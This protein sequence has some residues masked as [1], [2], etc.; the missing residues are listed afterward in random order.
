MIVGAID[1]G[2]N[3]VRIK[4][5][6]VRPD[7][8]RELVRQERDPI[9][10]GE[11]V[12]KSGLLPAAVQERLV[13]AMRRYGTLARRYG[14]TTR[15]VATSAVREA[16]N[17]D[18]VV[19]RVRQRAGVE[20]EVI[21]GQ[22]EARLICLGVLE[23]AAAG[24][25]SL[26]IDIGGGSTEIA[27]ARGETPTRL[28]SVALGSVRLTELFGA[29][30][31]VSRRTLRVMKTYAAEM[32]EH[33]LGPRRGRWPTHALGSSG[34]IGALVG[35]AS[36][37]ERI[38][39]R[40]QIRR[41]VELLAGL[42]GD[43]RRRH[44][45]ARRADIVVAGGVILESLCD[46]LG[47]DQVEAV[48]RGLRDGVLIDLIRRSQPREGDQTLA[49]AALE[50]GRRLGFEEAHGAQV[51]RIAVALYQV[52]QPLH[53]LPARCRSL[54][55]AAALLHDV[56]HLVNHQRHHRHS[57][58]IIRNLDLAG[59]TEAER[60][61]VACI[62]RFHRQSPPEVDHAGMAELTDEQ[63]RWV[64]KLATIL[65]LADT[66]DRSH[67]QLL[68][69]MDAAVDRRCV[70]LGLRGRAP[71][72]LERDRGPDRRLGE[73]EG[74]VTGQR[75]QARDAV[76]ELDVSRAAQADRRVH[77]DRTRQGLDRQRRRSDI[78]LPAGHRELDRVGPR[79]PQHLAGEDGE[80]D[81]GRDLL[82][83]QLR[84]RAQGGLAHPRQHLARR[85][86]PACRRGHEQQ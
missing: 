85:L 70:W 22:E 13:V 2:S 36:G 5:V 29:S 48:D 15:A 17:R 4:L 78:Q 28:V 33:E 20:L 24:R 11:R 19:E 7:G 53:R 68:R 83:G 77:P 64:R 56:G 49:R 47:I 57:Y 63:A 16:R 46:G 39:T 38:A 10:P 84:D 71:L 21:S 72:D 8:R 66:L 73:R 76:D 42:D 31:R 6:R 58:Y 43:E 44:F 79:T 25:R 86:E 52:L 54:L 74:H 67:H 82:S 14:A 45:D 32:I 12:F 62:A 40:K 35:F 61:I 81:V 37:G 69:R 65:R 18:R 9:R 1:V 80:I 60:E 75:A 51:S 55:E 30:S 26:C 34:T 3:A 59:V 41:A 50:A 23:G 27:L